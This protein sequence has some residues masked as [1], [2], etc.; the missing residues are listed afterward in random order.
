MLTSL[1]A[2]P[3]NPSDFQLKHTPR[4]SKENWPD[5][6]RVG[7]LSPDPTNPRPVFSPPT[8]PRDEPAK[9]ESSK[10][11]ALI[12]NV[13]EEVEYVPEVEEQE[14]A[15]DGDMDTEL[16]DE[17]DEEEVLEMTSI[18]DI[19]VTLPKDEALDQYVRHTSA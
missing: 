7:L 9:E 5:E 2:V 18:D 4:I 16:E 6:W 1:A 10:P 12:S 15:Y 11:L 8:K 13:K 17:E 3:F 19:R 14:Q